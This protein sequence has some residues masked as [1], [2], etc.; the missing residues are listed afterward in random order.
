MITF[1][2]IKQNKNAHKER[3]LKFSFRNI[4][5]QLRYEDDNQ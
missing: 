2:I 5:Q 4:S 1:T 3:F